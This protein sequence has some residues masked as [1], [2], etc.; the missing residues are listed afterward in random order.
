VHIKGINEPIESLTLAFRS[1]P[2]F[3]QFSRENLEKIV[4]F[5]LSHGKDL[6]LPVNDA[7]SVVGGHIDERN[8]RSPDS[9][10][11]YFERGQLY[12]RAGMYSAA[13]AD[14]DCV[15]AVTGFDNPYFL[16]AR[17]CRGQAYMQLGNRT[18]AQA[19]LES[20]MQAASDRT[21]VR[22]AKRWINEM[23]RS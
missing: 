21:K 13:L 18:Q 19:D 1:Q 16:E 6:P 17:F 20:Y 15:V 12:L 23:K 7:I 4:T 10:K 11:G 22:Q 3:E 14:L 5:S 9:L 8:P 2:Y